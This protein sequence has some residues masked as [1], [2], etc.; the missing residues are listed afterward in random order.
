MSHP[1]CCILGYNEVSDSVMSIPLQDITE[2]GTQAV[3][4]KFCK[5][6]AKLLP[7]LYIHWTI[8]GS[9]EGGQT[10]GPC[11]GYGMAHQDSF[12][13]ELLNHRDIVMDSSHLPNHVITGAVVVATPVMERGSARSAADL[14]KDITN[15][16]MLGILSQEEYD[17]KR[18]ETI[19]SI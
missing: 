1:T 3:M 9:G 8:R 19:D 6:C 17:K 18:Q 5:P 15:L 14:I 10:V 13:C 4:D 16:R 7:A 2:C 11:Y 12:A